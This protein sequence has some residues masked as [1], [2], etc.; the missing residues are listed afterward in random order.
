MMVISIMGLWYLKM[1][2]CGSLFEK[3]L[4]KEINLII[5]YFNCLFLVIRIEVMKML[6]KVEEVLGFFVFLLNLLCLIWE[7]VC[8]FCRLFFKLNLWFVMY[9]VKKFRMILC[10]VVVFELY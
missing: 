4:V 3:I 1:K 8:V 9:V 10:E 5:I 2:Y 6:V 7:V